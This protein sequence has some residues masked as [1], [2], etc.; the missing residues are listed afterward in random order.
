[1]FTTAV[2]GFR[3]FLE[4]FLIV[5]IFLGVSKKMA[6]K[7]EME[8]GLAAGVG[9]VLALLLNIGVFFLGAHT[10][11]MVTEHNADAIACQSVSKYKKRNF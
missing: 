11:S 7:K 6:L 8:I 2:I 9:L 1:M 3:E 5:G 4:A 10:Q